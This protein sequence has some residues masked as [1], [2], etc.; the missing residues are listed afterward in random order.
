LI[1]HISSSRTWQPHQLPNESTASF[2]TSSEI[3]SYPTTDYVRS[4]EIQN[5]PV[6]LK[7]Q[8]SPRN[9]IL[10][11]PQGGTDDSKEFYENLE[12]SSLERISDEQSTPQQRPLLPNE[13]VP[14]DESSYEGSLLYSPVKEELSPSWTEH[15]DN[16][17]LG[18][19]A[20]DTNFESEDE[21]FENVAADPY[22][23]D[24]HEGSLPDGK[25]YQSMVH[26]RTL[27]DNPY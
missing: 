6:A 19:S 22:S 25:G 1:L 16:D 27:N 11:G 7:T 2:E 18:F 4:P 23:S 9:E 14:L 10:N 13:L 21:N 15:R 3:V 20:S 5:I 26:E 12:L 24:A 17:L 8:V